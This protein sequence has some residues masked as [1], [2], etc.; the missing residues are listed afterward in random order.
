MTVTDRRRRAATPCG[1][2][3]AAQPLGRDRPARLAWDGATDAG[4]RAP[5]GIYR[6][7]VG[8][9]RQGR[10]VTFPRE[11]RLDTT[12]PAPSVVRLDASAK[13]RGDQWI[14]GPLAAP[15]SV[16]VRDASQRGPTAFRVLRTDDGAPHV[17]AR[18]A[19]SGPGVATATWDGRLDDGTDAPAGT[20]LIAVTVRDLA[21]N[22][23]TSPRA[24]AAARRRP[25]RP[26]RQRPPRPRPPAGRS[27]AGRRAPADVRGRLAR[28]AVPLADPPARRRRGPAPRPAPHAAASCSVRAPEGPSGRLPLRGPRGA[29]ERRHDGRAVRGAG[30][31]ARPH[32]RR[33]AGAHL[34]RLERRRR[35]PRRPARHAW[36]RRAPTLWPRLLTR[37]CPESLPDEVAPLL[38]FLDRRRA[39]ATTSRRTSRWPP[40]ARASRGR[41]AASCCPDRC[42]GSR[43]RSPAG[44]ATTSSAGG[45]VASFGADTPARAASRS[46]AR[47]C[48]G[49]CRRPPTTRSAPGCA[50]CAG[51]APT[52]RAPARRRRRATPAC[53]PGSTPSPASRTAGG[54]RAVRSASRSRWP[55]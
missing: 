45:T 25:R 18:F 10:A 30:R 44:C 17:V 7:R 15:V 55:R 33:P 40:P 42:A 43:A 11:I 6:V 36:R 35:R 20:Y 39:S 14:T 27:G 52:P 9:R 23:G 34:V 26:G 5:E 19:T 22:A 38:V 16:A 53:S 29:H 13:G 4:D 2:L 37:A 50:R 48:C 28:A 31:R 3:A 47:G 46:A 8:L 12:A 41:A 54:V 51:S 49:R 1:A 21:G 24:A 32:A